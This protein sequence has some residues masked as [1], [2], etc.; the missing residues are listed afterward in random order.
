MVLNFSVA[1]AGCFLSSVLFDVLENDWHG[2]KQKYAA[3]VYS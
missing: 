3:E 2:S 1:L